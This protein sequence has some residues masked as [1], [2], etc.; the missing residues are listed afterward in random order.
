VALV[1]RFGFGHGV[2]L[3]FGH[4]GLLNMRN[5]PRRRRPVLYDR[6]F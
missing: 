2:L 6:C 1:N 3:G 4:G 5:F